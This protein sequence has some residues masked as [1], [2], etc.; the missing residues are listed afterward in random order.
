MNKRKH[1]RTP[2]IINKLLRAAAELSYIF[3]EPLS[4]VA[5]SPYISDELFRHPL[6]C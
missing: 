1:E 3:D 6:N 4:R 5:E 2:Y